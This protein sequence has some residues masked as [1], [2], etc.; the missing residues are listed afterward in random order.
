MRAHRQF[1]VEFAFHG[2]GTW[3]YIRT[4]K[5]GEFVTK[6]VAI[7]GRYYG[8]PNS[9][10]AILGKILSAIG[11]GASLISLSR[12]SQTLLDC[13]KEY[14]GSSYTKTLVDCAIFHVQLLKQCLQ[15]TALVVFGTVDPVSMTKFSVNRLKG[16]GASK[17]DAI[18]VVSS[19]GY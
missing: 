1:G 10:L 4:W 18:E 2:C 5:S 15:K 17:L 14:I 13:Y 9:E 6:T 8:D 7:I 19:N 12:A 3:V 11:S 16:G